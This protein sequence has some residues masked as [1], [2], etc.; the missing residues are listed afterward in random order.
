MITIAQDHLGRRVH[1][2]ETASSM[3]Y[4]CPVCGSPLDTKK[5]NVRRHHFA[6]KASHRCTDTW[7]GT[8][9]DSEWHF[10]W[11]ERYPKENRELALVL[12]QTRHRADVIAGRTVVEFQHSALSPGEFNDRNRFYEDL[13]YKVIWLYDL[14]ELYEAGTISETEGT[15]ESTFTWDDPRQSFNAYD[16][17][18][19]TSDLFFQL[20][21]DDGGK[22]IVRVRGRDKTG[23][24]TFTIRGW[25]TADEFLA[26]TGCV[27]GDCPPPCLAPLEPNEAYLRFKERYGISLNG[28]QERA[29]QT[30]EGATLLLAVP[31]SGKTTVMIDRIGYLV[32]ERN[33][34]PSSIIAVSYNNPSVEEMR[35]RLASRF[36]DPR[37]AKAVELRT[38]NGLCYKICEDWYNSR[39]IVMPGII[40]DHE[41]KQAL[42]TLYRTE[43]EGFL[44]ERERIEIESAVSLVKNSK[45]GDADIAAIDDSIP[46]FS[47]IYRGYQEYLSTHNL[48]DW[49]DQMVYAQR[50]LAQ[51]ADLFARWRGKYRYWCVDEAQD[52]S[53]IQHQLIYNLAG[54]SGACNLFMVGDEDQSIYG[55]RG[56]RPT[57]LLNFKFNYRNPF[58][59]KLERNYRSGEEIVRAADAFING[60]SGRFEKHMTSE[61]GTGSVVRVA[62]ARSRIDQYRVARELLG[63]HDDAKSLAFI[64]RDNETGIPLVDQL[65]REGKP[66]QL[67]SKAN[68]F[69]TSSVALDIKAFMELALHPRD[70]KSFRQIW[71]KA[72][73]YIGR[74]DVEPTLGISRNSRKTIP[75]A[76]I[77]HMSADGD[78]RR[79]KNSRRFYAL[80]K[81]IPELAPREAIDCIM[82]WGYAEWLDDKGISDH[83]VNLLRL[84][85]ADEET[86]P[87]FLQRLS[88]LNEICKGKKEH[89]ES[90]MLTLTT[91]HSSKGRE[92]DTVVI[93]DAVD[94]TFPSSR[95]SPWNQSKDASKD[96]QE[97]RRLFYVA[98]TRARDELVLI[99][100]ANTRTPFVDEVV[101]R[102][103]NKPPDRQGDAV[104]ATFVSP[105]PRGRAIAR[106]TNAIAWNPPK[107]VVTRAFPEESRPRYDMGGWR[108][109]DRLNAHQRRVT[110][111]DID[112]M[113]TI[114][115]RDTYAD[116]VVDFDQKALHTVEKHLKELTRGI[117]GYTLCIDATKQQGDDRISIDDEAGTVTAKS[118]EFVAALHSISQL[119]AKDV[120]MSMT[121]VNDHGH[122]TGRSIE[123]ID[124]RSQMI[125]LSRGTLEVF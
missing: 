109:V 23:F 83:R 105:Q 31:G 74:D 82:G 76:L 85:A 79:S 29:V 121:Y 60:Y 38:I 48:M 33:V 17:K 71:S 56:A 117:A 99:R 118:E 20:R 64:Y 37:L 101:P 30:V 86:V 57:A 81:K 104:H 1:I 3:E 98:M 107:R 62:E 87:A 27:E 35:E 115:G 97:E 32:L 39:G 91:A 116:I 5:G 16:I 103:T 111:G 40:Q 75:G 25:V 113:L 68:T 52:T 120:E 9:S 19:G 44:P 88:Y 42:R 43:G 51:D 13:G 63:A 108:V 112:A 4:F 10:S 8:Y 6:H 67:L 11:Q 28:Q 49:D 26:Y 58:V 22:C 96:H 12:D 34:P 41:K 65:L 122:V 78:S 15:D 90:P 61:R 47:G 53:L 125:L 84:I 2:D 124:G 46:H 24:E 59:L 7:Q 92:F 89:P 94:G 95:M 36:N 69:F 80:M 123:R 21:N 100:P 70:E 93:L 55:F 54:G 73:C 114:D 66:F 72:G 18:T 106:P 14:R 45:L 110:N 77:E 119:L 102:K 50:F